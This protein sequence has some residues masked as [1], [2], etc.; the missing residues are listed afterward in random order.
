MSRRIGRVEACILSTLSTTPGKVSALELA[1]V[2]YDLQPNADGIVVVSENQATAVRHALSNLRRQ[3]K[4]FHLGRFYQGEPRSGEPPVGMWA[5]KA[6]AQQWGEANRCR[7]RHD[8]P[9]ARL[10]LAAAR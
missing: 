9:G 3:G 2:V 1:A 6:P 7:L 10:A 5:S 4:A 8:E